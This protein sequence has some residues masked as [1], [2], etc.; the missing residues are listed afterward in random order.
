[1]YN[2]DYMYAVD[3]SDEYLAH[4][5][6]KGM[7]WGVRK[8]IER[9]DQ[10]ALARH[11]RRA[12]KKLAKLERQASGQDKYNRRAARLGAAGAVAGG[13][14]AAGT[15]GIATLMKNNAK[16]AGFATR[17]AG[18]ALAGAG[19]ALSKIPG[20][21]GIAGKLVGAGYTMQ[22]HGT[23]NANA[24]YNAGTRLHS[25][26]ID[27][28]A[29][30][31]ADKYQSKANALKAAQGFSNAADP[32]KAK[33]YADRANQIRQA[34]A[35]LTN[36]KLLRAGS[37]A[38]GAGLLGAAAYNKYRASHTQQAAAKAKQFRA[39]MNKAFKG[40]QYANNP[41]SKKKVRRRR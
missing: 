1:M 24:V 35:S 8:A 17:G 38:L 27:N 18:T 4:Y 10:R 15:S 3:R 2:E 5:G 26:G 12:Q 9:G 20:A 16:Y 14:A 37:A 11:Y 6:I 40:T 33:M 23:R 31:L 29:N 19:K 22:S 28:P 41:S 30:H 39:E 32:G 36:E 25:W 21:S 13:L 34:G 7:R